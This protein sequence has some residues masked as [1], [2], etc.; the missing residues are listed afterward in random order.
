MKRRLVLILLAALAA[1][2][3]AETYTRGVGVYPGDPAEDFGPRMEVES[4]TYRNLAWNRAATQSSAYDYNLTAQLVTDGIRTTA[5]PRFVAVATS[6]QG[7]LPRHE[8]EHVLDDNPVTGV[9][10]PGEGAWVQVRQGGGTGALA[11]DRVQVV[12]Q[13]RPRMGRYEGWGCVVSASDDGEEWTEVGRAAGPER[14]VREFSPSIPLDAPTTAR[15]LRVACEA[16]G[17]VRWWVGNLAFFRGEDRVRIGGPYDFTSVWKSGGDAEEWVS[18]DLG[19]R[20][21]FDRLALYWLQRPAEGEV[22]VSDDAR[23]WKPLVALP[24]D[25][26]AVDELALP[27]P[28]RAR[29]VRV[30]MKRPSAPGGYVLS[31]MEVYG[32]GG[33]LPRP[34]PA[35]AMTEDDGK[36]R[37]SGGGWR[38]QRDSLVAADGA[39][40]SR[41]GFDDGG[42]LVATVPATV[43]SSY[44]N[45]GALPD[46]NFGDNQLAISDAFFYADFWYRNEFVA[47]RLEPGRRAWLDFAGINWKADVFLNGEA[48]GE[49]EGGFMR[50]R[51]DVTGILRGG[52]ANALAV[53]V[54][55]NASPGSAKEKTLESPDR[56]GGFLGADNPT[57]HAS[58]GWDWI[59][60]IRGR[61]TGIWGE[62]ALSTSGPVTMVAPVVS[63]TLPL[64]ETSSADV[65]IE[66]TL[67]NHDAAAVSGVLRGRFGDA[68]FEVPVT[69]G[70]ESAT[71]VTVDPASAPA[72]RLKHPR[73]WWPAGYGE[74]NLYDVQLEMVLSD[75]SVSDARSFRTGVRQ[76]TYSEEGRALKIWIN[77]RR[78]VAR[79]GNWGFPE[80]M[81]RYRAREYD[82]AVRYHRDMNFTMI[83]NWVGQTA[84]EAFFEAC[85]RHGIVVWQDFWLANPADGPNP[86]D[87][88]LFLRNA[89]DF[90]QRIRNHPSVGLYC[91]RNEGNPPTAL[92]EGLRDLVARLDPDV[93]YIS[94]SAFGVVSGGGPYRALP[95]K[96]YF[97]RRATT[98]LHSEMGMPNVVTMDSLRQMMP[99]KDRW[100][101]GAVWGMHD[102]CLQGAQGGASFRERIDKGY[103]GAEGAEEWVGLAQFVNYEGYRAMFEAQSAH[104]MGMLLWMSHPAWPSFVWQTYDYYFEPTGAYFACKK[105][106]EPLHVQWNPLTDAVEVVNYSAGDVSGLVA[107]AEILNLDGSLQWRGEG[108]LDSQEDSV[109]QALAL[110]FPA[111]LTPTH[112]VRLRLLRGEDVVSENFYWRG[113]ADGDFRALRELPRVP[114]EAKTKRARRGDTWTL[115]SALTNRGERPALMVRVKAVREKSGDRILPALFSDNYVALMP[116]ETR[117]ITT[118]V[119][120]ADTRGERPRVVVEGFNVV[121]VAGR[122]GRPRARSAARGKT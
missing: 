117:V 17:A 33:P 49:I 98:R 71:V 114:L 10:L 52:E 68:A 93:H 91:G 84:D 3:S 61:N 22:Q 70:G 51:F 83:R 44:W 37:L 28:A 120:D 6:E 121:E 15:V 35:P 32:K 40:L 43:L 29:H 12:G 94:N 4:A 66:A 78:F 58:V 82:V 26:G 53:R 56:N 7:E 103:G 38:L 41:P 118:E 92:D 30:V 16:A 46:P 48:L 1:P 64:P 39:A 119:D 108:T 42:W 101:Q 116:G 60:T 67:A 100:P 86:D 55:K 105:A 76:L 45:A 104:R 73:L 75:G 19:A 27:E 77:G 80:S 21:S 63:T 5:A 69:I 102:F 62:V 79:G 24:A 72:L 113:L 59:P 23:E 50:G 36:L 88:A 115:S 85:D 87:D 47:P 18:V 31:E 96:F 8:R 65:R 89:T 57:Y 122:E 81:L 34:K 90:I 112:F 111:T 9:D 74:P 13:V 107:R 97:Q 20:C 2:L 106:S 14:M 54:R 25:G 110:E 11:V 95:V 109:V 99:E